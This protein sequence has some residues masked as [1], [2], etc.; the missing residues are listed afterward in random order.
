MPGSRGAPE[1]TQACDAQRPMRP[2]K[3]RDRNGNQIAPLE[4]IDSDARMSSS[5]QD[6]EDQKR[7]G[8]D[9]E[10]M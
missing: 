3:T 8:D 2:A 4:G 5:A 9:R 10:E 6:T 1:S 7:T